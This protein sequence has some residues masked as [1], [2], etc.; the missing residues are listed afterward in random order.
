MLWYVGSVY[1]GLITSC[2]WID[3]LH[4]FKLI[5]C[6]LHLFLSVLLVVNYG[7]AYVLFLLAKR[8]V[9]SFWESPNAISSKDG[10][11]GQQSTGSS[12]PGGRRRSIF[13]PYRDSVLTWLL[14]DSLGGNAKT[15][16]I[17]SQYTNLCNRT[18]IV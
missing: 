3:Y 2:Q 4:F 11:M 17:A 13:I 16:M 9:L 8:S 18:S 15:I 1:Q 14:K 6:M 12:L 5:T 10:P 7:L